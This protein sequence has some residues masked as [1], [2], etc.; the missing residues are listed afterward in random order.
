MT[1]EEIRKLIEAVNTNNVYWRDIDGNVFKVLGIHLDYKEHDDD[2]LGE[3][4]ALL[5]RNLVAALYNTELSDFVT[6]TPL[7]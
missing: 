2:D 3:P 6:L 1:D 5:T 4:V 7:A